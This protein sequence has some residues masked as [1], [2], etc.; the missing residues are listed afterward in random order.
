MEAYSFTLNLTPT[1]LEGCYRE[2]HDDFT[3][4]IERRD[5]EKI[6]NFSIN[7]IARDFGLCSRLSS[8]SYLKR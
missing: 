7:P 3:V 6:C 5:G 4:A 2:L 1:N 8:T